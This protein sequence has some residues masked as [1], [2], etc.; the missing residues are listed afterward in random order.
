[1]APKSAT[2]NTM[3]KRKTARDKARAYRARMRA[4]GLKPVQFWLPDVNSP[5]FIAEALEHRS[6]WR[7]APPRRRIKRSSRPYRSGM[8]SSEA[9]RR[10]DRIGRSGL[11]WQ[12]PASRRRPEQPVRRHILGDGLR[13]D[14]DTARATLG[15]VAH[16]ADARKRLATVLLAHGRQVGD[17][18]AGQARPPNRTAKSGRHSAA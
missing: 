15:A 12:T 14:H 18:E 2:K 17:A 11:R 7:R 3:A 1:M 13:L 8:R 9:R 16:C 4:K 6:C 10:L 5:E